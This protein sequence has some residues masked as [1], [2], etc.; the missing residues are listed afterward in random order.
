MIYDTLKQAQARIAKA[1]TACGRNPSDVK[2]V[3]VSKYQSIESLKELYQYGVRDFGESRVQEAEAKIKELEG[4]I[5]WHMIGSLQTNKVRKVVGSFALIHS[6]D[7]FRLAEKIHAVSRELGLKTKVLLE[8]NT[9]QEVTK[10]GLKSEELLLAFP[11]FCKLGNI[12]IRG[13]M[14]MAPRRVG[15]DETQVRASFSKLRMLKEELLLHHPEIKNHFRELSMGM[16]EDFE[17]AIQ[18]GATIVR[19][20]SLIFTNQHIKNKFEFI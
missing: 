1:A 3:V 10:H 7:T 2:L 19:L 18:E 8:V 15:D 6:V 14:T 17:I 13:L 11:E 20:G 12:E 5:Q 4:D 9:S 16:S